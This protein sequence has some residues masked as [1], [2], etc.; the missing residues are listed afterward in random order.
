MSVMTFID[1][2]VDL[3]TP[4]PGGGFGDFLGTVRLAENKQPD[5]KITYTWF[6]LGGLF[7]GEGGDF[8]WVTWDG[9]ALSIWFDSMAIKEGRIFRVP[10]WERIGSKD[11]LTPPL[12]PWFKNGDTVSGVCKRD[13]SSI[14]DF[15][16]KFRK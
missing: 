7:S 6:W 13:N 9:K 10:K 14:I 3:F 16:G 8:D 4:K 12:H 15:S 2:Q 11:E 5:G 1:Y